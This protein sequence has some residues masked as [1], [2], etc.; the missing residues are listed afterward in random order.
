MNLD[1]RMLRHL[2]KLL[3]LAML[4]LFGLGLAVISS[5]AQGYAGAEQAHA[6]VM[7]QLVAGIIGLVLMVV[8]LLFDY[9]E[10]G[11]MAWPIYGLNVL[12][13]AAVLVIGKMTNGA[14]SWIPLGFFNLQPSEFGKVMLILTLG[15][16]L[17][18]TEHL[19]TIWDLV[20]VAIHVLPLLLLLL[21]QPDLGTALVFVVITI[22]MVYMAGF[23]GKWIALLVGGPIA[24][25]G[26]W[27]WAHMRFGV[28]MWP[29]KSHQ[30][31]R[32]ETFIDPTR[33]PMGDGYHVIQSKISIG[34]GGLFGQGLFH[35]T[36]NQLGF[37]PEQHTDFIFSVVGEELGFI[38]G[39]LVI[40]LF[41]LMLLRIFSIAGSAKDMYGSLIAT[42]VAAMIGFHV[43]E[44]IG[45]TLG[46]MPVTGI[47]LPFV[48]YGG[49]SLISNMVA[50]GLVLSVGMR[51]QKINF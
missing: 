41:L 16:Q 45:M 4:G 47:P 38:G 34:S 3:I 20:P 30:V 23:P 14:Q 21:L 25:A 50:I 39:G 15:H 28:S 49:S 31:A 9:E 51:R 18:Q 29:L 40:L 12:L 17:S 37:L 24:V 44:N 48:S 43:L 33:D 32:L 19:E 6:F 10:M 42:G 1:A 2:D 22:A 11:R 8:I 36:Q 27:L 13:L 5:A 46:V 35:G 7:K 26:G